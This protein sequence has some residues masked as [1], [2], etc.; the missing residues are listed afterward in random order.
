MVKKTSSDD[1]IRMKCPYCKY[2]W[3]YNGRLI[4]AS[5][6]SCRRGVE[7]TKNKVI[8]PEIKKTEG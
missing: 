4:R 1:G 8:N 3:N 6:P 5:C 7:V 2:E